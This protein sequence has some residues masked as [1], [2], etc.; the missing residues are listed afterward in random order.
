MNV[1]VE[2]KPN[3]LATLHV[4]LPPERVEK[5]WL[6]VAKQFQKLAKIP[7]YR[8]G[9][10]PQALVEKKFSADIREELTNKLL[11]QAMNE[12]IEE[13]KLRVISVS[14]VDDVKID[15]DKSMRFTA[16]VVTSPDFELPD[17]S[18]IEL[19][20]AK[21]EVTDADVEQALT[22]IAEQHADFETIEG[23]A[24][25][26][27]D[28]AIL[29]YAAIVDGKPIAEVIADVPPLLAG[30][31]NWWIRMAPGT[32]APGFC[33]ALVGLTVDETR[34]FDIPIPEDFPYEPVRGRTLHYTS[35]LHEIRVRVLPPL[36]DDLAAKIEAGKTM[37][38]IRERVRTELGRQAENQFES[39]KRSGAIQFLLR[40]VTCDL[41]QQMVNNEMT[42]ILREIVQENQV[43]G[44]SDE[45][46]KAHED[47]IMGAAKQSA[48]ERVR[49][50]FLLLRIAEK[51]GIQATDQDLAFHVTQLAARY[52]I[53][54]QKMVKD[55]QR[56]NAFGNIREQIL[57]GKALDL[58]ASNV[59]VREPSGQPVQPA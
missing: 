5:E 53:P 23:R 2:T 44:V 49:S 15:P 6:A 12:A 34:E 37:D 27:D 19:E 7:G 33:D 24:L 13:K 57:A 36:D 8:P 14:K 52:E 41:P 51:E 38:E 43:R 42:G 47:E 30:K 22:S 46:L 3:C 16:T 31:P 26:M 10:A 1:V 32:L 18:N 28:F 39:G 25:A 21:H 9:K 17:Y 45:E 59:T 56:R 40:S 48:A 50:T 58:I 29:S 35:T 20:L 55:L 11:R 4:E 54:V